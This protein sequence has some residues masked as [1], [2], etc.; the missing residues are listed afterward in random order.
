MSKPA[1]GKDKKLSK[2][3]PVVEKVEEFQEMNGYGKFEFQNKILYIGSYKQLKTGL[4]I[5]EGKGKL[6]HPTNDNSEFGQEYFEGDWKEDKMDGFGVYHYSNGD[7]YEGEWKENMHNGFGKYFFTDGSR[8]EGDWKD[9]RMHGTGKYWDINNVNWTGEFRDGHYISKEQARLKEEKRIQKKIARMKEHPF[10]FLKTWEEAFAKVDKKTVKD[11]LSPFFAKVEN[12]AV[13]V[14]ENY[15]KFEDRTPEKWNEALK[16]TINNSL[17]VNS[18]GSNL[19]TGAGTTPLNS[20]TN[21]NKT[22]IN[23]PK[24]S[25]ELIF[26]NKESLLTPQLQEELSSGQV[27]EIQTQVDLRK[28]NLGIAYNRDVNKWLIVFFNEIIEKKK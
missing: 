21:W 5:R 26:M 4:K 11:I 28:I 22:I 1:A 10:Q 7:V 9:H 20:Q 19:I 13:F 14:K 25:T 3:E 18:P 16:F 12:M 6:I 2:A 27:I 24:N 15:P 17:L 8:Y 23:V